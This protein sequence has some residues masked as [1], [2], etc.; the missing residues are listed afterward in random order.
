MLRGS[1]LIST[2]SVFAGTPATAT[3]KNTMNQR[4][5]MASFVDKS[6]VEV[7]GRSEGSDYR[8]QGCC[9]HS[10]EVASDGNEPEEN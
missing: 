9:Q 3:P 5:P 2:G 7:T 1:G 4:M 8:Q 6:P 10:D